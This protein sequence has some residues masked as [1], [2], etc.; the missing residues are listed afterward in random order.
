MKMEEDLA[1]AQKQHAAEVEALQTRVTELEH[2]NASK[3]WLEHTSIVTVVYGLI[4][5]AWFVALM[6]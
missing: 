4:K 2:C 5:G 6:L 3:L 1:A